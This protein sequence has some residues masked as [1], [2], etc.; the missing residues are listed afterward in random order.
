MRDRRDQLI[1]ELR[2]RIDE[3]EAENDALRAQPARVWEPPVVLGLTGAQAAILRRLRAGSGCVSKQQLLDALCEGRLDDPPQ[4]K[5]VDVLICHV[6][7]K[8][9]PWGVVIDTIWGR[10]YELTAAGRAAL[11]AVEAGG[12][13]RGQE[14]HA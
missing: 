9:A 14:M 13:G 1:E 6:R 5:I 12:A 7:R 10:G 2:A 11:A 3:L 4:I 8:T